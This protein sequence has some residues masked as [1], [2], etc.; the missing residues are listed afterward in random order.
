MAVGKPPDDGDHLLGGLALTEDRFG[1]AVAKRPMHVH[2][3][4]AQVLDGKVPEAAERLLGRHGA[5]GHG[6][7]QRLY[8]LAIH[9]RA[10]LALPLL[11]PW[12]SSVT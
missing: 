2:A 10:S 12:R 3:R 4:E 8:F 9:R 6:L 5:G 11:N 7:Q 1:H